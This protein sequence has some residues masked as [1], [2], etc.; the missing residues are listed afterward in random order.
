MEAHKIQMVMDKYGPPSSVTPKDTRVW[1]SMR[2]TLLVG[3]LPYAAFCL[4][5]QGHPVISHHVHER[6]LSPRRGTRYVCH[7]L[8]EYKIKSDIEIPHSL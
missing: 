4:N 7:E 3:T 5:A 6:E 1:L 8:V 2:T